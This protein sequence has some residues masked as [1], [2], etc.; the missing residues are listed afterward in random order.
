M[1]T[2]NSVSIVI[3]MRNE[4]NHIKKCLDSLLCQDLIGSDIEIIVVDGDSE[5]NSYEIANETLL[6]NSNFKILHNPKKITPISLNIGVKASRGDIVII[7][8]A[9][10]YVAKDFVSK[11]IHFLNNFYFEYLSHQQYLM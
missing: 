9:H 8:G 2:Y 4:S 7:L 10:S 5:D 1:S 6:N 3:P 11:N